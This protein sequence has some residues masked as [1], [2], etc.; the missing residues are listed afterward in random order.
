VRARREKGRGRCD[1]GTRSERKRRA[2]RERHRER[3][4]YRR[5]VTEYQTGEKRERELV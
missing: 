3:V 5:D 1:E 2:E 4:D